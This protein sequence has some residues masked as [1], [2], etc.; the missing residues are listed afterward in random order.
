MLLSSGA[1]VNLAHTVL[2]AVGSY[3]NHLKFRAYLIGTSIFGL[4]FLIQQYNEYKFALYFNWTQS[5]FGT[6]FFSTTGFHGLHVFVGLLMLIYGFFREFRL[7]IPHIT[8]SG[9]Y[10]LK[11]GFVFYFYKFIFR[12]IKLKIYELCSRANLDLI[13]ILVLFYCF[14]QVFSN[15]KNNLPAFVIQHFLIV[16]S[17]TFFI[18]CL[19]VYILELEFRR[20]R[21]LGREKEFRDTYTF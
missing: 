9:K 3:T 8:I 5:I 16:L 14:F 18:F 11:T 17:I 2:L 1:Y 6:L 12:I 15:R 19:L 13:R 4:F 21:L 7:R 20:K 10:C